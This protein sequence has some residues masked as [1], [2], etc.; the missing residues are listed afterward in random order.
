MW[1]P[2]GNWLGTVTPSGG[3]IY[4]SIDQNFHT[5]GCLFLPPSG[6]NAGVVRF[7]LDG[8]LHSEYDVAI[9]TT[10]QLSVLPLQ[11]LALKLMTNAN[12]NTRPFHVDYVRVWQRTAT[13]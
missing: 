2:A 5:Y 4:F 9:P 3:S 6:G 8:T 10:G 1:N 7:Y 13:S 12:A 11:K